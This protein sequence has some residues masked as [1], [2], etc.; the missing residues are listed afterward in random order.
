MGDKHRVDVASDGQRMDKFLS[1]LPSVGSRRRAREAIDSGKVLVGGKRVGVADHALTVQAGD[2]VT[3]EWN[4]PGTARPGRRG[5]V[6]LERHGLRVVHEDRDIV[7]L[8]KPPGLLTDSATY[9][10]AREEKTVATLLNSWLKAA[11]QRAHVVHRID[12]DTSGLVAVARHEEAFEHL[13]AEFANHRPVRDY[14]VLVV[15]GPAEDAGDWAHFMRWD[16]KFRRQRV[17]SAD[18]EQAVVAR[19]SY[20]VLRRFGNRATAL[21]VRLHTGR[22][23]QIRLHCQLEGY[24]L[25]GERQYV[26]KDAPR[27]A[28]QAPRQALHAMRLRFKHPGDGRMVEYACALPPD[29]EALVSKLGG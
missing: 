17:A 14:W 6:N 20:R 25:V 11:E 1:A 26:N 10:Q 8:D 23:N 4:R 27:P 19:A 12:R 13:R 7:V 24:P 16:R 2:L 3:I 18:D 21:E 22:R 9:K 15:G 5:A 28:I 29:L